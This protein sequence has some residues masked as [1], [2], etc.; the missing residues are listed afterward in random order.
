MAC[1]I[2]GRGGDHFWLPVEKVVKSHPEWVCELIAAYLDRLLLVIGA[3]GS[4]ED[5]PFE[6]GRESTGEQVIADA[7]NSA[8]QSFLELLLPRVISLMEIYADRSHGP[9]WR[10]RGV[11]TRRYQPQRWIG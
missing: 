9:P 8:P 4:G 7:A 2:P 1:S 5:F 6:F 3:S 11:G 10:D